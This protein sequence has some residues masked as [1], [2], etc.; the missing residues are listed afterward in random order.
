MANET[1]LEKNRAFWDEQAQTFD[2]EP[3]HG[4]RNSK[5]K[6]AW[7]NLFRSWLPPSSAQ[8][9]DIG[10]GTGSLSV[11]LAEL[12]HRIM[13][14]DYSPVMIAQA[15]LKSQPFHRQIEYRVMEASNPDFP[16]QS[17]DG[18]V[19]R[20]LLWALPAPAQALK[21]WSKLLKPKGHIILIEGYWQ[22][23]GGLHAEEILQWLPKN[24]ENVKVQDLSAQSDYWGRSVD[25]ERFAITAEISNEMSE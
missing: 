23:G 10:C 24:F 16:T 4:L 22:T 15:K 1:D 25:D 5:V 18:L 2:E 12:G 21:S 7:Q 6:R 13:G 14:I 20:H 19:C 8:I 11:L 3:D 17:F 9:L